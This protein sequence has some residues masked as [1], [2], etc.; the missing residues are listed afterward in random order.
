M[1]L[2]HEDLLFFSIPP[3]GPILVSPADTKRKIRASRVEQPFNRHLQQPLASKPIVVK[4]KAMYAESARQLN[5]AFQNRFVCKIIIPNRRVGNVR[6]IM[7]RELRLSSPNIGP[8][9][10]A[11]AP[12]SV[13][14]WNSMKLGQ[15]KCD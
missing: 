7:L 2:G 8:F 11:L 6:L 10:E 5:L 13:V 4:T 9:G 12:P 1:L 3:A 14:L 15:V